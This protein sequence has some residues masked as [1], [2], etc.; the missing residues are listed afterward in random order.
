MIL[1][2][3]VDT[4]LS[5]G[6]LF[7]TSLS[8]ASAEDEGSQGP[9]GL[10]TQRLED[11]K[12]TIKLSPDHAF[13]DSSD[14]D[15][16][17][18]A[19]SAV[20]PFCK[21][22][23]FLCHVRCLQRGDPKDAGN[24]QA[25]FRGEIN[26]CIQVPNSKSIRVLCLC[27]NGVDLTAEVD[28]ALEGIV[29]IKAAGGD[30]T[31]SGEAGLIR[32]V[33]YIQT[34]T[35]IEY[36]TTTVTKTET[37][38]ATVTETVTKAPDATPTGQD[39]LGLSRAKQQHPNKQTQKKPTPGPGSIKKTS[40]SKKQEGSVGSVDKNAQSPLGMD[41]G[42]VSGEESYLDQGDWSHFPDSYQEPYLAKEYTSIIDDEERAYAE[43]AE[44]E[45]EGEAIL[46]DKEGEDTAYSDGT[47]DAPPSKK[48]PLAGT[49]TLSLRRNENDHDGDDNDSNG[50]DTGADSDADVDADSEADADV[51]TNIKHH[52]KS[53]TNGYVD[54]KSQHGRYRYDREEMYPPFDVEAAPA[55]K[56][57]EPH[58]NSNNKDEKQQQNHSKHRPPKHSAKDHQEQRRVRV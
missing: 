37:T 28:Y 46:W 58:K 14:F 11:L 41:L 27:N 49:I 10:T 19:A 24:D 7:I 23:A 22:F 35:K 36:R 53:D 57:T 52:E 54:D 39:P 30:G 32:E 31:G 18:L 13:Y 26:R 29:D 34:K 20:S 8:L 16:G 44:V 2:H 25:R 6:I 45:A 15:D 17:E 9:L 47:R 38:T 4:V 51:H 40:K 50:D 1:R 42:P 3:R 48:Q 5:L 12:Q 56:N 33:A 21:S 55:Y 43:A